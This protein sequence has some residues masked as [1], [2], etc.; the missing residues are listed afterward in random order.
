MDPTILNDLLASLRDSIFNVLTQNGTPFQQLGLT[1]FRTLVISMIVIAGI[2]I[3][4]SDHH[5]LH[6]LRTLAG[7]VLIV[8]IMLTLHAPQPFAGRLFILGSHSA[9]RFR[10]GRSGRSDDPT[11]DAR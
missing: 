7:F 10:H 5:S 3:A 6:K 1:I 8:W 4:F 2:R 11:P 9:K